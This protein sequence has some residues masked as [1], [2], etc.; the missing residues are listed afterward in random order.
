MNTPT[1][2]P[3]HVPTQPTNLNESWR[4][5]FEILDKAEADGKSPFAIIGSPAYRALPPKERSKVSFNFFAF[6]FSV[7]YYWVKGMW[8]KGFLIWGISNLIAIPFIFL[9]AFTGIDIPTFI[10]P[11]VLAGMLA[12]IDYYNHVKNGQKV[13]PGTPAILST[14][15]GAAIFAVVTLALDIVITLAAFGHLPV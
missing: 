6:L 10:I 14:V 12:N 9:V 8:A 1:S 2:S 13:W 7:L 5:K 15:A 4:K 11:A 3:S